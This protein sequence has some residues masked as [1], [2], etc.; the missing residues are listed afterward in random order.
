MEK[1]V[2]AQL[3]ATSRGPL[4][5][6]RE[7]TDNSGWQYLPTKRPESCIVRDSASAA[8]GYGHC[9][10]SLSDTCAT[11]AASGRDT[12]RGQTTSKSPLLLD[13]LKVDELE[14][15]R[16]IGEAD[17]VSSVRRKIGDAM[18]VYMDR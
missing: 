15:E 8:G 3:V 12:F 5:G 18:R 11:T 9:K 1:Q 4:T 17:K 16:P 7:G 2:S 14:V 13:T 6:E 10:K